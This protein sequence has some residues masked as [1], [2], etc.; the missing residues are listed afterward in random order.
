MDAVSLDFPLGPSKAYANRV[1]RLWL[2]SKRFLFSCS[3]YRAHPHVRDSNR[4]QHRIGYFAWKLR[5]TCPN[6]SFFS[7]EQGFVNAM[8]KPLNE[9]DLAYV[10]MWTPPIYSFCNYETIGESS[11]LSNARTTSALRL[12]MGAAS[13]GLRS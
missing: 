5:A 12:C 8:L 1:L 7:S 6:R 10:F 13:A 4:Q 9:Y 2:I 11:G 3:C